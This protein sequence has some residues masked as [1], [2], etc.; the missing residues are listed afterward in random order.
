[1]F[2]GLVEEIGTI[3]N[4]KLRSGSKIFTVEAKKILSDLKIDDSVALNGACQTVTSISGNIFTVQAVEETLSKTTLNT[5]QTGKVVN[6]ERALTLA[7]RLGGHLV[8]GHIDTIGKITSINALSTA[9]LLE[10]EY[11]ESFTKY[12]VNAGSIAIDGVSLTIAKKN[13]NKVTLS[14][15]PHTWDNT[16]LYKLKTGDNVNIEFDLIAKYIENFFKSSENIDKIG[17]Q[18][19]SELSMWIDQPN[20]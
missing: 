19:K 1:M 13:D 2:T 4:V 20:I 17:S 10:I 6:L 14:I 15:I 16:V 3:R 5:W 18:K 8:Q 9:R 7:S 12:T 11:P